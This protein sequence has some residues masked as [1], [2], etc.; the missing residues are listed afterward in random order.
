MVFIFDN[1]LF[2]N[3]V[4]LYLFLII[5]FPLPP[6]LLSLGWA[7]ALVIFERYTK[8][9]FHFGIDK[10]GMPTYFSQYYFLY[11]KW[12]FSNC[13]GSYI[14]F[15]LSSKIQ[16]FTHLNFTSKQ[17]PLCI[18]CFY[19]GCSLRSQHLCYD[20]SL[21]YVQ[22]LILCVQCGTNLLPYFL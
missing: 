8:K 14:F 2:L 11:F 17:L 22:S 4:Y 19:R 20:L 6:L 3:T 10:F 16:I 13:F 15:Y 1:F 12:L 18:K 7:H 9:T 5:F 21:N